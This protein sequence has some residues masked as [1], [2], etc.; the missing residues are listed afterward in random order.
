MSTPCTHHLP[1]GLGYAYMRSRDQCLRLNRIIM[2]PTPLLE[3][4][5][6]KVI[7]LLRIPRQQR[8]I[9]RHADAFAECLNR[10][11]RRIEHIIRID[12]T[13]LM[14]G[15]LGSTTLNLDVGP[16]R[17]A[18][19]NESLANEV[20]KVS[21]QLVIPS[22]SGIIVMEPGDLVQGRNCAAVVRGHTEVRVADEEGEMESLLDLARHDGWIACLGGC[23]VRVWST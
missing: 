10:R 16:G 4:M 7:I 6:R 20:V 9:I 1:V 5:T 8:R 11:R 22:L 3:A 23:V 14:N 15:L 13:N 19:S 2:E 18:R 17:Y 12:D 21:P